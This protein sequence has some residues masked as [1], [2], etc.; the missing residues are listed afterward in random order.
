MAFRVKTPTVEEQFERILALPWVRR[1]PGTA[2]EDP[3]INNWLFTLARACAKRP[4]GIRAAVMDQLIDLTR[5]AMTRPE[6]GN[7]VARAFKRAYGQVATGQGAP[8]GPHVEVGEYD[9]DLLAEVAMEVPEITSE[10][11]ASVSP[12]NVDLSPADYFAAVFPG[13]K[14][15]STIWPMTKSGFVYEGPHEAKELQRYLDGNKG[16]AWYLSNPLM[17]RGATLATAVR[18]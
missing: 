6:K 7:E 14:V 2:P 15:F 10:W 3:C 17:A 5:M 16:G 11:S 9:P 4:Y 8:A 12:V 18:Q 13:E 1:C